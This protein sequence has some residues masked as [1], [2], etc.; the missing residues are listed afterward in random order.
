MRRTSLGNAATTEDLRDGL[1]ALRIA[2]HER[3]KAAV[4]AF[5]AVDGDGK[6]NRREVGVLL[7]GIVGKILSPEARDAI[8]HDAGGGKEEKAG[9]I[10][11]DKLLRALSLSIERVSID[12][13]RDADRHS[14]ERPAHLV[15]VAD[16][17]EGSM[18]KANFDRLVDLGKPKTP[19]HKTSHASLV[20]SSL[21]NEVATTSTTSKTEELNWLT[22]HVL[23]LERAQD[24]SKEATEPQREKEGIERE[25]CPN[26]LNQW[27]SIDSEISQASTVAALPRSR[28]S[29]DSE[30]S[31]ASTAAVFRRSRGSFE[32]FMPLSRETSHA[33]LLDASLAKEVAT[34]STTSKAEELNSLILRVHA[35]ERAQKTPNSTTELEREKEEE[36]EPDLDIERG[37]DELDVPPAPSTDRLNTT[38][39]AAAHEWRKRV[40][41]SP[42]PT[43]SPVKTRKTRADTAP[44]LLAWTDDMP[45]PGAGGGAGRGEAARVVVVTSDDGS[46]VTGDGPVTVKA[47]AELPR[48][49]IVTDPAAT[50]VASEADGCGAVSD[51]PN[52][53]EGLVTTR[54]FMAAP[55]SKLPPPRATIANESARLAREE[56]IERMQRRREERDAKRRMQP[57]GWSGEDLDNNDDTPASLRPLTFDLG[58]KPIIESRRRSR[59]AQAWFT[60]RLADTSY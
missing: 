59:A 23:A 38:A 27:L 41:E 37:E 16:V 46:M 22:L 26:D 56:A 19:S 47:V 4:H 12:E 30:T 17:E 42:Q 9:G 34:T 29:F 14:R 60:R 18:M 45:A 43:F 7:K 53:T 40:D 11:K 10:T 24:T 21:V 1:K 5:Y 36:G 44:V 15:A 33:N 51:A 32:E 57:T 13:R 28:V 54:P 8:M 52:A 3:N 35:L 20:D 48:G 31:E 49:G 39:T 55:P 2:Q 6:L 25:Q 58:A 50:T